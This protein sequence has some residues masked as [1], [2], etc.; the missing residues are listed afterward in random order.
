MFSL[1]QE[2]DKWCSQFR[3]EKVTHQD[4]FTELRDHIVSAMDDYQLEGYTEPE[5]FDLAL[6][7]LGP[8][9]K[10]IVEY[11]KN[12][13]LVGEKLVKNISYL[14]F[15]FAFIEFVDWI[16][17]GSNTLFFSIATPSYILMGWLLQ[18]NN[19]IARTLLQSASLLI[20]IGMTAVLLAFPLIALEATDNIRVSMLFL[21]VSGNPAL[22][23]SFVQFL[24][25]FI[26]HFWLFNVL[27][28]PEVRLYFDSSFEEGISA[29][30]Q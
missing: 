2:F 15:L 6:R 16:S 20:M 21:K 26:L 7:Q 18:R 22:I 25:N 5:S 27:D 9:E 14:S 8:A 19:N 12:S 11:Q 10:L 1:D 4:Y 23:L 24:G 3:K 13:L 17:G 29:V 28:K 30:D